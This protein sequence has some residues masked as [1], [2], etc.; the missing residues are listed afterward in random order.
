MLVRK[1]PGKWLVK[2]FISWDIDRNWHC[3]N[4]LFPLKTNS[5][6]LKAGTDNEKTRVNEKARVTFAFQT[7][8][9]Q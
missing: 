3:C 7:I 6:H 9:T 4:R 2:V 5:G 8:M 1:Y